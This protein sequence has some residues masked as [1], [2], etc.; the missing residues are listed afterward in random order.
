[1]L[2]LILNYIQKYKNAVKVIYFTDKVWNR[3]L[4]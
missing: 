3:A 4:I 1:M 2:Y